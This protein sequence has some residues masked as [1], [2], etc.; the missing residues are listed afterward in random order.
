MISENSK[1]Y[2][3]KRN[4]GYY[5]VLI[6]FRD[7][8][9][10]R[11]Q[12]YISTHSK[13][14]AEAYKFLS[15]FKENQ[16]K[17][18]ER[19][20]IHYKLSDLRIVILNYIRINR[21]PGSVLKY[22]TTFRYLIEFLNDKYIN[23]INFA[24][25]EFFKTQL[26]KKKIRETTINSY[27]RTT[28]AT[29]NY[30]LKL[31]VISE[32]KVK[33]VN[34]FKIP[35]TNIISFTDEELK[36]IESNTDDKFKNMIRFAALTGLRISEQINLQIKDI[37]N[38][39][40]NVTNKCDFTTKSKKNRIIPINNEIQNVINRILGNTDSTIINLHNPE[41]YLFNNNGCKYNRKNISNKFKGVIYRL[42]LDKRYHW[43]NLRAFYIMNLVRK[44]ISPLIIKS[45]TGHSSLAVLEKYCEVQKSDLVK[46]MND[47]F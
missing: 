18:I 12:R 23:L 29:F 5:Y 42:N 33:Y 4:N 41:E 16:K 3:T 35:E 13:L 31:G 22:E 46:A 27:I 20:K 39:F 8:V 14:K 34:Q 36:L 32:N 47:Y 9:N 17:L 37:K 40:I 26:L 7:S 28:K 1:Y 38:G 30:A 19:S 21:S 24:D 11:H 45:L 25:I 15:E 2:L 6:I 44:G 10:K 43:H